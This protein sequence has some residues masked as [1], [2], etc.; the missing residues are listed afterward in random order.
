[1]KHL[2][3]IMETPRTDTIEDLRNMKVIRR[4]IDKGPLKGSITTKTQG[5]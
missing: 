4:L 1:V 3:G 2:P 5:K